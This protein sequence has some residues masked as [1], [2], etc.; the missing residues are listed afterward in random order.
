VKLRCTAALLI[1]M[2]LLATAQARHRA[3]LPIP[4]RS[5]GSEGVGNPAG[6]FAAMKAVSD[7]RIRDDIQYLSSDK[8]EGRGTGA[9]GGDLAADYI[10]QQFA[11][12][13]LKPAG[14]NGTYFQDVPMV[15]LT[16]LDSSTLTLSSSKRKLDLKQLD[17][18]VLCDESQQER[19]ELA[20]KLIF[21]GYGITAPEYGWD[22]YA[23]LDVKGKILLMLVNE[24]PSDDPKFFAGKAM[25]YYGRWTYKY[26][27]AAAMGAA[28]VIL[29]HKTEMASYGWEVVRSS[30]SGERS[31]LATEDKGLHLASW[32]QQE[33]I[34]QLLADNGFDLDELIARAG[35]PGFRAI[36]LEIEAQAS[37]ASRVRRFHSRNVLG[38]V[39]GS[40]EKLKDEAILYTAHYDH[41]GI[42]ATPEGRKIY[43]GANDNA[44]GSAILMEMARAAAATPEKPKRTL[45]FASVTAEE[46]GLWGSKYLGEHS[47]VQVSKI[48]LDLNFDEF[49]PLGIPREVT[50]PGVE[51]TSFEGIFNKTASDFKMKVLP[52][53]L[54]DDGGYYRSD[55]FSLARVGVPAISINMGERFDGHSEEWVRSNMARMEK[56]YHQPEDAFWPEGDFRADAVMARFGLALGY[57]AAALPQRIEWRAGDEFEARRKA[58]Q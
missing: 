25:T 50:A 21:A 46:Q 44:S 12:A 6:M 29:I 1:C 35:K 10:A 26:E 42:R 17:D 52:A 24:P 5:H 36:P 45:L 37:I 18:V 22:D 4:H 9:K 30:W 43:P 16:T 19:S 11:A 32:I 55:H 54:P 14:E 38:L 20:G 27:H 53:P 31:T 58:Q 15:G 51:R 13:G 28:G 56:N 7:T 23:G 33:K 8:L 48:S 47:P 57:R 40:D 39:E 49:Y 3:S 41:L 2:S 34:R